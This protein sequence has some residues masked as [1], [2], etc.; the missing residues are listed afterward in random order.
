MQAPDRSFTGRRRDRKTHWSVAFADR[1]AGTLIA[2]GGIGIIIAVLGVSLF[3]LWV[4]IPLFLPASTTER[5]EPAVPPPPAE[6]LHAALDDHLSMGWTLHR[7]GL[8]RVFHL[9]DGRLLKETNPFEGREELTA[10]SFAAG[11]SEAIFGFADGAVQLGTVRFR[12]SFLSR[13]EAEQFPEDFTPDDDPIPYG[14]GVATRTS[15]GQIRLLQLG[16]D[17]QEPLEPASSSP[18][19]SI[20]LSVRPTGPTYTALHEDGTMLIRMLRRQRN[21]MTGETT[22]R[23]RSAVLPAVEQQ[24]QPPRHLLISNTGDAV[25]LAWSEGLLARYDARNLDDPRVVER[26]QLLPPGR[27]LTALQFLLGGTT[28]I[29]GDSHGEL[30]AWF[31]IRKDDAGTPDNSTLVRAHHL[32]DAEGAA[33]TALGMSSRSRVLAA[34]FENGRV[35]L[36]NVTSH[37]KLA[38]V[39]VSGSGPVESVTL[40]PRN[41]GLLAFDPQ[42]VTF[43]GLD[44]RHPE[45]TPASLFLPVWYEGFTEPATVWQSSSGS[46]AFEPKY[47]LWPL[48][49]GTLK[50]TF[51]SMLFAIPLALL[52]A[53]YTSEYLHPRVRARVKPSIELMASLPSVVLGFLA[54]IVIA[55]FVENWVPAVLAMCLTVPV[56]FLIGAYGWQLLPAQWTIRYASWRLTGT[57]IMIP[58]GI[59]SALPGGW[60]VEQYLFAGNIRLWLDGQIGGAT[61]GWALIFLPL[62]VIAVVFG[63]M[64]AVDDWMRRSTVGWSKRAVAALDAAKFLVGL[65]AA[66]ALAF[67][68]GTLLTLLGFD[69]RGSVVDTYVQRNALIVGFIMGFAV[70]PIIYTIAE[71]ALSTVPNHLRSASLGAGATPW[72]TATR[73]VIPTAMSGLFSAVMVGLG[74]AVGETMIVLMAAG[75]TPILDLNIFS[76]FRTLSANIAVELPEAVRNSTHY[77]T[78]FLAALVLFIMTFAINTVAEMVRLRFRKRAVEL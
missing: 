14:T 23:V 20:G 49:F 35:R 50:A 71:D 31:L 43:W 15:E 21:L 33:V 10:V 42:G 36:L 55:P 74:R 59:L 12:T 62:S 34:G 17:L 16:V 48:I 18:V 60:L 53:I 41:N 19:R 29:T 37:K 30:S 63:P 28:L 5:Q 39:T 8:L 44:M 27:E 64:R 66:I 9:S 25:Y 40:A 77:R 1:V 72:Q 7:G 70:I 57:A 69:P 52:A 24:G 22:Y 51:Y 26:V 6:I 75:N 32:L 54:G 76:G 73:V 68:I 38:D 67:V 65:A 2:A 13:E 11:R 4:V 45:A 46:D 3:L 58:L 56:A 61:G 47:G 78:L